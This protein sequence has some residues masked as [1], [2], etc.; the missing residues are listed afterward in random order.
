MDILAA[1]RQE[2]SKF[3]K[4]VDE[5]RQQLETVR[6]AIKL[7][8][9]IRSGSKSTGQT[10]RKKKAMSAATKAKIAKKAKERWAKIR[11]ENKA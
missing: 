1:L 3:E 11:A 9:G 5:A 8:G 6:A 2:E 10:T 4:Q 7:M